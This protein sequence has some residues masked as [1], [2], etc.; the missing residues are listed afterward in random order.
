M[1]RREFLRAVLITGA[2]G[3]VPGCASSPEAD[4]LSCSDDI[5]RNRKRSIRFAHITD[6]H[7]RPEYAG[8]KGL[9]YALRHVQNHKD[10]PELI[11][12]TGDAVFDVLYH[13]QERLDLEW[14]LWTKITKQECSVPIKSCIGNHDVFGWVQKAA[15]TTG[16]EVLY[17]KKA[18]V[19]YLGMPGRYY[20]FDQAGWHFVALDGIQPGEG[21]PA[22]FKS[23]LDDEQFVWLGN[24]LAATGADTPVVVFSHPPV[25]SVN[26]QLWEQ[27]WNEGHWTLNDASRIIK[28]FREHR[29]VK[30]CLGGHN[31]MHDHVIFEGVSYISGGAISSGKWSSMVLNG[32]QAGYGMVDLYVD[33][34]FEYEYITHD[35]KARPIE[36]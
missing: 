5:S 10:G 26:G 17:G 7:V 4:K 6:C 14:G 22:G 27:M 24:D 33:G 2:A 35:W 15:K 16:Q 29:N 19:H 11:I 12:N 8:D 9:A 20:S 31:H 1:K 23:G 25:L 21:A 36:G 30:L 18:P 32:C 3:V 13:P 34:S 28:L